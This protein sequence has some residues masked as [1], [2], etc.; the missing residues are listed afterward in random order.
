MFSNSKLVKDIKG[1]TNKGEME[2]SFLYEWSYHEKFVQI[3]A[4]FFFWFGKVACF[5]P[6]CG[7]NRRHWSK[8]KKIQ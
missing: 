5:C 7:K 2:V 1:I 6:F 4:V 8:A 3:S